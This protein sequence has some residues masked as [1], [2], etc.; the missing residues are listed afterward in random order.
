VSTLTELG[1]YLVTKSIGTLGT[2]LFLGPLPMGVSAG[3]AVQMMSGGSPVRAMGAALSAPIADS[4]IFQVVVR[5]TDH[6]TGESKVSAIINALDHYWGTLTGTQYLYMAL[7]YGPVY[8]GLDENNR[9][10]W[11]ITFRATKRRS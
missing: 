2:T 4:P 8:L 5:N 10:R 7:E 9:H 3:V 6:D 1:A 11:S